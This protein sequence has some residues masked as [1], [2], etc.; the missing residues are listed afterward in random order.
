MDRI[1]RHRPGD[2]IGDEDE[3][4]EVF[5]EHHHNTAGRRTQNF[6]NADLFGSPFGR[7]GGQTDQTEAR[8][9]NRQSGTAADQ[10]PYSRF[11]RIKVP[12]IFEG[13]LKRSV[14]QEPL[15][16]RFQKIKCFR[17]VFRPDLYPDE[18]VKGLPHA[19]DDRADSGL[20]RPVME[21]LYNTDHLS[22]LFFESEC[23]SNWIRPSQPFHG[24]LVQNK[25]LS[26]V[27]LDLR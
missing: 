18:S 25:R 26:S 6:A 3:F 11:S 16:G 9:E 5:G 27:G 19:K 4:D 21:V 22:N 13:I 1:I 17:D 7:E 12:L 10:I 2:E 8:Y 20:H 23:L 24:R 15:P 14:G